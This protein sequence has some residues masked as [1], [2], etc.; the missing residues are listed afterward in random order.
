MKLGNHEQV[1]SDCSALQAIGILNL[2][3]LKSL[4]LDRALQYYLSKTIALFAIHCK[5]AMGAYPA[6]QSA[7]SIPVEQ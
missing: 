7:K 1:D 6:H 5:Y 3:Q 2:T 4:K